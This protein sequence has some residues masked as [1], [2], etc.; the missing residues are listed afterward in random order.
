MKQKM[1]LE[2]CQWC[3]AEIAGEQG[4]LSIGDRETALSQLVLFQANDDLDFAILTLSGLIADP[5][6]ERVKP[7]AMTRLEQLSMA[8]V[9]DRLAQIGQ[10]GYLAAVSNF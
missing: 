2:D 5:A 8:A 6:I 4:E 3:L 10:S 9:A 1:S 7:G